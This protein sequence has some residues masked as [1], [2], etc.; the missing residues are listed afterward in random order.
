MEL[1]VLS[2]SYPLSIILT[3]LEVVMRKVILFSSITPPGSEGHQGKLK[4]K[5]TYPLVNINV[6]NV[7]EIATTWL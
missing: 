6:S 4:H 2:I 3:V 5:L 7:K 1:V